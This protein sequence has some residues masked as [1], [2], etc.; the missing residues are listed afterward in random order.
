MIQIQFVRGLNETTIP[1]IRLTRSNSRETG[2]ATFHFH[3]PDIFSI[4][5]K[6]CSEI[7]GMYIL[8]KNRI[9]KT[10]YIKIYFKNGKPETL[11]AIYILRNIDE[12]NKLIKI[13]NQFSEQN[14][15]IFMKANIQD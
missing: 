14:N 6:E 8:N 12:W 15:L 11:E 7:T 2:T 10:R 3:R 9:I 4:N 13:L 1:E 5:W